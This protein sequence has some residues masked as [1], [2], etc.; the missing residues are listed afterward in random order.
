MPGFSPSKDYDRPTVTTRGFFEGWNNNH[1]L[2]LIDGIPFNDNLYGS[3]YTWEITPLF[4]IKSLEIIKGPG[5]ALYGSNATNGVVNINT[6]SYDDIK[7]GSILKFRFGNYN[8]KIF[9]AL[10]GGR[11]KYFSYVMGFN[12]Y[13]TDGNEY[14]S[15]DNSGRK[16]LNGNLIK[17]KTNDKR[18]SL[19][20]FSKIEGYKILKGLTM[21]FHFQEWSF[22]TGHGWLWCI[23]EFD[24]SMK[25]SRL[26]FSVSYK[27]HK[28]NNFDL[29][30][31][32]RYQRHNIDWNI[33]YFYNG[34]FDNYYPA[35][36][37]EYLNTYADD[38]WGRYQAIYSL[39]NGGNIL[40]GIEGSM[41][42]Y[43]GDN[44]HYS[45]VD[46]ANE[47]G[48]IMA[49]GTFVPPYS[50]MWASF[51]DGQM[52]QMGPW[53]EWI[54]G[55]PLVN[56]AFYAQFFSGK[57]LGNNFFLTFGIRYDNQFFKYNDI[58][59]GIYTAK[60]R[61][62]SSEFSP[63]IGIVFKPIDNYSIKLLTGKAFRSPSPTEMFGSNTW[64]LASN[65]KE[66][67]PEFITTSE[68]AFDVKLNKNYNLRF[69]G[70][71]TEFENQIAY[72]V[73]NNNLST[74]IYNLT[75]AGIEAELLFGFDRINGFI[76]YSFVKR[77]NEKIIDT[78]IFY[79]KDKLTWAP[80]S[81]FNFGINYIYNN[82]SF[83][84]SGHYQGKVLR[85]KSDR[86]NKLYLPLRP[87]EV[88]SWLTFDFNVVYKLK[89]YFE[90]GLNM[91]NIL[92]SKNY[93]IKNF[94]YP[95]DYK[96]QGRTFL[97]ILKLTL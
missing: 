55:N 78:T 11:G 96:M 19:Y 33:N 47:G 18:N 60:K 26:L 17:F 72:S 8:T 53:L 63:R 43:N 85:R 36:V 42:F 69:N 77:V 64:T 7:E 20:F 40:G 62:T 87:E 84:L 75:N 74:N 46:L 29:E 16:D 54:K 79:S 73:Q 25:E 34:A 97:F 39:D 21:E 22:Q 65:L 3:A 30:Y 15:Y 35:G 68:I 4:M 9:D 14:Y 38:I 82:L 61:K 92:D 49:D 91:K 80:S 95:F 1:L 31:S 28:V 10:S 23:P 83:S 2:L 6:I 57:M 94:D 86:L 50:K 52:R 13:G 27:Q 71:Y 66:L 24:E 88:D 59:A 5:S 93:L 37:I 12:I 81:N 90:I 32:L 76:N 89:S 51:P 56:I 58:Y 41:F 48:F 44:E 70:Y 67:K 45:N